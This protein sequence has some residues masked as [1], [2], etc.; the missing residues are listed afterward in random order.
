MPISTDPL[1][2]VRQL[3][4]EVPLIDG[5]NDLPWQF[6]RRKKGCAGINLATDTGRLTPPLLTDIPRLR[7]GGV[8]GQFWSIYVPVQLA[9]TAALC[10]SIEQ[11][12]LVHEWVAQYAET[13]EFAASAEEIEQIHRRGKIASLIGIEGGHCINNSLAALRMMYRL[14]ARYLTLTHVRNTDWADAAGDEP[15]HGGLTAFGEDVVREMNRLGMMV[16]LSHVADETMRAALRVSR[17]PVIFS[18]SST[19]GVCHHPRNVPDDILQQVRRNGG[20]VMVCFLPGYLNDP[21]SAHWTL[22]TAEKKRLDSVYPDEPEKAESA[23]EF[24]SRKNPFP[25]PRLTDVANHIDHL[26]RVAGIEHIGIGSDFEGYFGSVTGLEDVACYPALLCELRQRG[27][28]V[29]ELKQI[30]GLNFLRVFR[31]VER[32]AAELQRAA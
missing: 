29:D 21:A 12:D 24:W 17:A 31:Q 23:M 15:K 8:G 27:Y 30:A 11:I 26:R 13:F 19:R 16:D 2:E 3:L 1:S 5:H 20:I 14:G 18:H 28:S 9:G 10:A 22:A 7:A 6:R 32:L 25:P 4:R